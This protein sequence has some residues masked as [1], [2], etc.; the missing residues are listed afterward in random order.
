MNIDVIDI[1]FDVLGDYFALNNSEID[2][3]NG[4]I[5]N[6]GDA[7]TTIGIFNKGILTNISNIDLGG[8]NVDNDIS[9]IYK[10]PTNVAR[11]LKEEFALAHKRLASQSEDINLVN[12]DGESITINQ[13]EISKVVYS[14]LNEILSIAKKEINRITKK[15]LGYLI[16]TG[17]MTEMNDFKLVL[18]D[19][20]GKSVMIGHLNALGA[21]NNKYSSA[22]GIIKWYNYIQQLKDKEY[23][24]LSI[25][26]Q[27]N[28]SGIHKQG[29]ANDN[30]VI[31]KV[32]GYF[33]DN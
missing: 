3:K 28:F 25:E 4:A 26:E 5:I 10:L 22:L 14:R 15:E 6:I 16:F 1:A 8:A 23:S 20:F 19:N 30:S 21:R 33:F 9:Y 31:G 24:I 7:K 2:N 12:K 13:F 17:G 11:K 29:L 32:F 27:E 18:E